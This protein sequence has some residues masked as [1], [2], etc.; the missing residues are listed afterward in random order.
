MKKLFFTICFIV[1]VVLQNSAMADVRS[2]ADM[3]SVERNPQFKSEQDIIDVESL[4]DPNNEV[5]VRNFFKKRFEEA[6]QS[7]I[8]ANDNP[9]VS[10][11][12]GVIYS[13]EYYEAQAEEKKST[14]Q[15]IYE[16]AVAA[17]NKKE[18]SKRPAVV[19]TNASAV[20]NNEEQISQTATRFFKLAEPQKVQTPLEE[21]IPSVRITLPSGRKF[22]APAD[23]H[24]PYVL[25][26]INVQ[27]NGF[28]KVEDTIIIVANSNKFKYGL[29]RFFPKYNSKSSKNR[30]KIELI[31][32]EVDIN[33]TKVPYIQEEIGDNLILKPKYMQKLEAGVY[34]YTFKYLIDNKLQDKD[35][36]VL[37][38][39][40][41]TGSPL[42]AFITSA[43]AIIVL[44]F[45]H[46]FS[47]WQTIIGSA[48]RGYFTNR[49]NA[50]LLDKNVLAVSATTPI[51]NMESMNVGALMDKNMFMKEYNRTFARFM[52]DWGK[53]IYAVAGLFAILISYILSL[54]TLKQNK[55]KHRFKPSYDGALM[56]SIMVGKYDRTAFISQLLNMYRRKLIDIN[57]NQGRIFVSKTVADG[58]KTQKAE[59]KILRILFGRKSNETEVNTVNNKRFKKVFRLLE[60]NNQKQVN[61][62]RIMHNIMYIL[63]STAMLLLTQIFIAYISVNFAQSLIILLSTALLAAFYI[64]IIRYKFKHRFIGVFI[65]ALSIMALMVLWFFS[66]IYIGKIAAVLLIVM[67]AV[68][69]EFSRIFGEYN[70]FIND[71]KNTIDTYKKYLIANAD[72]I[73][74]SRDFVN[75][76]ANIF[77]LDIEEY[78]PQNVSNKNVYRLN[79]ADNLKQFLI[80]VL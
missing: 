44:P 33:G 64:W 23:E 75:Q 49:A 80:D 50:F 73:N 37:L 30:H 27:P 31:L 21:Q 62:Y 35:R 28:L 59:R 32:E 56:R 43:N 12:V 77:A 24:I 74:L 38:D 10:A 9:N 76:Q 40:N 6:A 69:F 68:I 47:N 18:E 55:K 7:T 39:W 61:K 70:N 54:I 71:A 57:E 52:L 2:I 14:F 67:V 58:A 42:N 51:L 29:S 46:T 36:K 48:S 53:E 3:Q 13:P 25:S 78:Y 11:S 17:L 66:S 79:V 34:T 72:A 65:K 60:K 16:E 4:P 1:A 26:Y 15:K 19:S 45:G 41:I 8:D 20:S 22:L 63:F 5:A